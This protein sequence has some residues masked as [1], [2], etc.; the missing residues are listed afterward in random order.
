M[1]FQVIVRLTLMKN[2]GKVSRVSRVGEVTILNSMAKET[3]PEIMTSEQNPEGSKGM[4]R[5]HIWGKSLSSRE[6]Y[7]KKIPE[8]GHGCHFL[9]I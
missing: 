1:V 9:E 6:L 8:A 3:F 5:A 7:V 2:K 4:S